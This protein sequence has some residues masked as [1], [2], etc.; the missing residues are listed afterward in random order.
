M[1]DFE[2]TSDEKS[3]DSDAAIVRKGVRDFSASA[4]G[5]ADFLFLRGFARDESGEVIG[6]LVGGTYW[7]WLHIESLWVS[8]EHRRKGYA[9]RL[10]DMT[11][12]EGV[13]RGFS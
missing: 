9:S 5:E 8:E 3:S 10:L 4:I 7:R 6:G 1:P 13:R 11:E 2:L 12:A